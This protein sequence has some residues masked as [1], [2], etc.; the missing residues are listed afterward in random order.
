MQ[1]KEALVNSMAQAIPCDMSVFKLPKGICKS[2]T[3][4]I[5]GFW[6]GDNEEK[7]KMHWFARWKLCIAKKNG[8]LGFRNLHNFNLAMLAKQC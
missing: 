7:R 4:E 6:W 2:I 5:S 8:G 1:S 3:N